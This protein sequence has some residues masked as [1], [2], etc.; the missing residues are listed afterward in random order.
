[1]LVPLV[2]VPDH[3]PWTTVRYLRRLVAER[4]IGY[5]KP[6]PGRVLLDLDE[7]DALAE[8]NRTEPV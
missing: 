4:R 8:S 3:R 6:T 5:F 2:E 7:L 1:V